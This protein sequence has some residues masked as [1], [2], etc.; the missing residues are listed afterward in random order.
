MEPGSR[1]ET[2]GVRR[3]EAA[4]ERIERGEDPREAAAAVGLDIPLFGDEIRRV[5]DVAIRLHDAPIALVGELVDVY[6]LRFALEAL[7]WQPLARAENGDW[8]I[9]DPEEWWVARIRARDPRGTPW[10]FRVDTSE[11]SEQVLSVRQGAGS[12]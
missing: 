11:I 1:P 3:L 9:P 7:E 5:I 2:E 6:T 4:R 12:E 8:H 10:E